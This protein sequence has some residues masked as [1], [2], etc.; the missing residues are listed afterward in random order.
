MIERFK[1]NSLLDVYSLIRYKLFG[2]DSPL[3][4][5]DINALDDVY[6]KITNG[7]RKSGDNKKSVVDAIENYI[8]GL[9][10]LTV[11]D[12]SNKGMIDRL[13]SFDLSLI[14]DLNFPESSEVRR[15]G[16]IFKKFDD[17]L[18][19]RYNN[20]NSAYIDIV[21]RMVQENGMINTVEDLVSTFYI[22]NKHMKYSP[23]DVIKQVRH[24]IDPFTGDKYIS[25][26]TFNEHDGIE[27]Y[28]LIPYREGLNFENIYY[29]KRVS[30]NGV[31]HNLRFKDVP[32]QVN[33]EEYLKFQ[34]M[35][36]VRRLKNIVDRLYS[37]DQGIINS[38]PNRDK[39]PAASS[40]GKY[41]VNYK[42]LVYLALK[43]DPDFLTRPHESIETDAVTVLENVV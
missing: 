33:D 42:P 5:Q 24:V 20:I 15:L 37:E 18:T 1:T 9:T 6:S 17:V 22:R 32:D 2:N 19:I 36:N 11:L 7:V 38:Y 31:M 14:D 4:L 43:Y 10:L 3:E 16:D 40:G 12:N 30:I 25:F 21:D 23:I 34:H 28:D 27:M 35:N 13:N 41:H 8:N 29:P 26:K 39:S